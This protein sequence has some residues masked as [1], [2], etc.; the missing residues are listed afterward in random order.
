MRRRKL[1]ITE[2]LSE[3]NSKLKACVELCADIVGVDLKSACHNEPNSTV[4][5][6]ENIL[7][8]VEWRTEAILGALQDAQE[9][10]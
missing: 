4:Q 5:E 6:M 1:G 7:D 9:R 10:L 3:V 2:R 8:T